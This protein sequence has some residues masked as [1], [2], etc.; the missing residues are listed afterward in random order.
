VTEW[1][2]RPSFQ[3]PITIHYNST[4]VTLMD[5]AGQV[6]ELH[7]LESPAFNRTVKRLVSNYEKRRLHQCPPSDGTKHTS[8]Q[9]A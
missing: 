6:V 5:G 8:P 2:F 7:K 9:S 3:F 1:F 4:A